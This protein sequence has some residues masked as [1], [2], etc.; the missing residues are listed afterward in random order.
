[1]KCEEV[2]WKT[3]KEGIVSPRII[4]WPWEVTKA[5]HS[6]RLRKRFGHFYRQQVKPVTIANVKKTTMGKKTKSLALG[7]TDL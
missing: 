6:A 7:P 5:K 4:T 1:M 2:Q 3:D